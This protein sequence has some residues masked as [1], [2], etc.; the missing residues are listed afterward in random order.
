MLIHVLNSCSEHVITPNWPY[1]FTDSVQS[2]DSGGA[3][4]YMGPTNERLVFYQ[5][6]HESPDTVLY[7]NTKIFINRIHISTVTL[8][9]G[10]VN[11]SIIVGQ[12][13]LHLEIEAVGLCGDN[14]THTIDEKAF[15]CKC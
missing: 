9:S 15:K 13:T 14:A 11:G 6:S 3:A 8:P 4:V 2:P 7:Y 5:W 12:G 1:I 10:T